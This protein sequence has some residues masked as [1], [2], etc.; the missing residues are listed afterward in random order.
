MG[1][2]IPGGGQGRGQSGDAEIRHAAERGGG[3]PGGHQHGC[4]WPGKIHL[5]SGSRR[6]CTTPPPSPPRDTHGPRHSGETILTAKAG[7]TGG[8]GG[9]KGDTGTPSA[10]G[11]FDVFGLE[12]GLIQGHGT[13]ALRRAAV[14]RFARLPRGTGGAGDAG[15]TLLSHGARGAHLPVAWWPLGTWKRWREKGRWQ[16]VGDGNKPQHGASGHAEGGGSP[17]G[18]GGP[19]SPITPTP[20]SP[21]SPLAPGSPG[22]EVDGEG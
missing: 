2:L 11:T 16:G 1:L 8:G 6:S 7:G 12:K 3:R 20:F 19:L 14:P 10:K 22:R 5:P 18:P 15:D 17:G 13:Q 21:F 4:I 9:G